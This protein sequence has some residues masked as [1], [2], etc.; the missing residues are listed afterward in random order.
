MIPV[1][2]PWTVLGLDPDADEA[3]LKRRYT[4]LVLANPPDRD[5]ER[6][7]AIRSAYETALDPRAQAR[8]LLFGPP[9][10]R[11]LTELATLLRSRMRSPVG[12]RA[13]LDVLQEL[14]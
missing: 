7:A 14:S 13:W 3:T 9:P 8:S 12:A 2:D 6:F 11:D 1:D 4:E 10:L 5:P